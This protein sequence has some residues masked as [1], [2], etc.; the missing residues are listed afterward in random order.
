ML[1]MPCNQC[2]R[3]RDC[4]Y[5]EGKRAALQ[6]TG[7][8]VAKFACPILKDDY[9]PGRRVRVLLQCWEHHEESECVEAAF[10]GTVMR[11]VG[12][13]LLIHLDSGESEDEGISSN[14]PM[15]KVWPRW[16]EPLDKPDRK[17][18]EVCGLPP[19]AVI[20]DWHCGCQPNQSFANE[21]A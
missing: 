20:A 7:L 19:K 5:R 10:I 15:V 16:A 6:G 17:S 18:C 8:T 12:R 21:A 4:E 13:K 14:K 2:R 11:W 1:L 3:A 9:R